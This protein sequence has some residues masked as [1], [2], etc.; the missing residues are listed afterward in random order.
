LFV[1]AYLPALALDAR[2]QG[3]VLL[4]VVTSSK[5]AQQIAVVN[6]L[7][8]GLD[9]QSTNAVREWLFEPAVGPDGTPVNIHQNIEVMFHLR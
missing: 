9:H 5:V 6:S 4:D 8:L 7:G 3:N 2:R 1:V